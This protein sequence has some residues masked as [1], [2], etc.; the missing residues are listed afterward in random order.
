MPS[1]LT[2]WRIVTEALRCLPAAEQPHATA[3]KL[4]TPPGAPADPGHDIP[5]LAFVG[6]IGPD[7]PYNAGITN[8]STFFP[9]KSERANRG[10]SEWADLLHYNQSGAFLIELLRA[11]SQVNNLDLR[12]KAL[13][14]ALGHATHIAGDT[15]LHPFTN[16]FAGAYHHQSN[17][18]AFNGLGVHFYSEFCNDLATD[19]E[20][21]SANPHSIV[22]RPWLR[23]L[24]G[25]HAELTHT[26]DGVSLLDLLK[27]TARSVYQLDNAR[28]E[29]FGQQFLSGL[30]GAQT[31]LSWFSY[32]PSAN[33]FLRFSPRISTYF[34]QQTIAAADGQ[35][36]QTLTFPQVRT[37][38]TR[39]GGRLCSLTAAYYADLT[40]GLPADGESYTRLRHDLRDWNLDTGYALDQTRSDGDAE[41]R[42]PTLTLRHSWYHFLPL[43]SGLSADEPVAADQL[44]AQSR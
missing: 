41:Q 28:M 33:V 18:A 43:R 6:A 40:A 5:V 27:Q 12:Q 44:G 2:H 14:Y 37:F 20:F 39:V 42:M 8:R 36:S 21:F 24:A 1:T 19:L 15:I 26:H 31:L 7:L 30:Q 22:R 32:Y 3:L 35:G 38:A 11:G 17:T 34:A 16:T 13:Y 29:A 23:Y 10:K 9:S 4:K 25:A